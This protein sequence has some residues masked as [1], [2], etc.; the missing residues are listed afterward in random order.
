[1]AGGAFIVWVA[2]VSL[3]VYALAISREAHPEKLARLL[4]IGGG[5]V[6]PTVVLTV[7]LVFG[8]SRMPDLMT[9]PGADGLHIEVAG[10][11]WWWRVRYHPEDGEPLESANEIRL[12]VGE[13]V[14]FT[15]SSYDIIHSFWIPSLGGKID[16]IPGR[17]NRLTLEPTRTGVF[18]GVCAEFCGTAHALMAFTV[19]VMER[20][21]FDA[22]LREARGPAAPPTTPLAERGADLFLSNG[23]GA[24]HAVRGTPAAGQVGPDLTRVGSR[25][26]LAAGT[27]PNEPEAMRRWLARP[28]AVKP[29]ARMPGYHMLPD[30][31]LDAIAA[32]MESLQ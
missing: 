1:M 16:M 13:R 24:C 19:V 8:L 23:C 27:L 31:E 22:W 9:P 21:A 14:H 7:L 17:V 25:A 29:G 5:A 10:E 3:A 15:V 30:E 26:T 12:P 4:I 2:V 6:I 32:Y 11:E 28:E 18:R 20:D